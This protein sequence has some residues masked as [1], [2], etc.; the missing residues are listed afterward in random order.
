MKIKEN[1][2]TFIVCSLIL[3]KKN[4]DLDSRNSNLNI[5]PKEGSSANIEQMIDLN[6]SV[7]TQDDNIP[8]NDNELIEKDLEELFVNQSLQDESNQLE[9]NHLEKSYVAPRESMTKSGMSKTSI[10]NRGLTPQQMLEGITKRVASTDPTQKYISRTR[11]DSVKSF[12]VP[13]TEKGHIIENLPFNDK[14]VT[15]QSYKENNEN[16]KKEFNELFECLSKKD[17][18]LK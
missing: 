6:E 16:K 14:N 4:I 10:K 2:A 8:E 12:L 15:F 13:N 18:I 7:I 1:I 11:I 9:T 17:V 3:K 5:L